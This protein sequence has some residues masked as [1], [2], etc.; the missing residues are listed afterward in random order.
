MHTDRSIARPEIGTLTL[1]IGR[2]VVI[3]LEQFGAEVGRLEV[4]DRY[5][6]PVDRARVRVTAPKSVA[7]RR[8]ENDKEAS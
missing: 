6:R 1:T 5:G 7:I 8:V 2:G 4:V 3:A